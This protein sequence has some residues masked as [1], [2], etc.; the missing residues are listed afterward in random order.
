MSNFDQTC[1]RYRPDTRIAPGYN[2]C[3]LSCGPGCGGER[4]TSSRSR[5]KGASNEKIDSSV[6]P[7]ELLRDVRSRRA[8]SQSDRQTS[9]ESECSALF[10][11]CQES[12]KE[13]K[14]AKEFMQLKATVL[15]DLDR[16]EKS[17]ATKPKI[18]SVRDPNLNHQNTRNAAV[19]SATVG[20][21]RK[22][23][24]QA[25]SPVQP[26]SLKSAAGTAVFSRTP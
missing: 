20:Q 10:R 1:E 24:T 18:A 25:T 15:A 7:S 2:Q 21:N 19:Y 12:L 4:L 23:S 14:E 13:F 5:A 9:G 16:L 11:E 17:R 8:S 22:S 26:V 6:S 3:A